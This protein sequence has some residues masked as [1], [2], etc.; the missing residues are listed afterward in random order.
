MHVDGSA[1]PDG[2]EGWLFRTDGGEVYSVRKGE[3]WFLVDS[4]RPSKPCD[5]IVS[6]TLAPDGRLAYGVVEGGH[7]FVVD[8]QQG[9]AYE[10][11]RANLWG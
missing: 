11:V 6:P 1:G 7:A 2:N 3:S 9:E 10:F 4:E 8:G 5:E